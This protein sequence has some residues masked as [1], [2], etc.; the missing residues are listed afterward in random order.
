[1][2]KLGC[3]TDCLKR[4][5]VC[6]KWSGLWYFCKCVGSALLLG[7]KALVLQ[8]GD[9]MMWASSGFC[10]GGFSFSKPKEETSAAVKKMKSHNSDR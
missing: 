8:H 1:M 4:V 9:E 5:V 7:L 3:W 10:D 2:E 6:K